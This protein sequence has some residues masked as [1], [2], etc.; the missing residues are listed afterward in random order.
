MAKLLIGT[1]TTLDVQDTVV[2]AAFV[3][4]GLR[5][6]MSSRLQRIFAQP[7]AQR[8]TEVLT[9]GCQGK[10]GVVLS[11]PEFVPDENYGGNFYE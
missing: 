6:V 9:D 5:R 11:C 8:W 2:F 3:N 4:R 1:K 7:V 10:A